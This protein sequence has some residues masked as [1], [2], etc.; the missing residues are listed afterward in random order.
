LSPNIKV[1]IADDHTIV[2]SGVRLLL[3]AEPDIDVVGEALDGGEA[4]S[5]TEKLQPDVVLMDIAM[6]DVDGLE[7]TRQIKTDWPA[8]NV[9]VLTMHRRDEY[10]F[11]MLKAGASGYVL[12]GADTNELI[13]AVRVVAQGDVF[14][15]PTM[16]RKLVCDYLE[17]VSAGNEPN[18]VLTTR[19]EQILRALAEGY[20]SKEIAEKLVIS[21]S[22]V[23]THRSRIM[24]K[25]GLTT[26]HE[27][28]QYARRHGLLSDTSRS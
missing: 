2:R 17:R 9:L 7:A 12:K 18:S 21:A 1:I 11:E 5:L 6:P 25:L 14:L 4:I 20:N 15:Y 28:I 8:I 24:A 19:E 27:L 16:T 10:F 3:Q 13:H 26:R 22:T 23:Y